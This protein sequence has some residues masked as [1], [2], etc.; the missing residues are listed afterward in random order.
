[1]LQHVID[2]SLLEGML[3]IIM[4][5]FVWKSSTQSLKWQFIQSANYSFCIGF[6]LSQRLFC[7]ER[8]GLNFC[9]IV[10]HKEKNQGQPWIFLL[11]VINCN[12]TYYADFKF[13]IKKGSFAYQHYLFMITA[14]EEK[15]QKSCN[16][17]L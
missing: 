8:L 14:K 7:L 15:C 13:L 6:D 10:E 2:R 5:Y 11:N 1:M 17:N 3:S 16:Y 4:L 9:W 12:T